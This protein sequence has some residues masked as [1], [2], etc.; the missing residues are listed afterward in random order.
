MNAPE[1][2]RLA[3]YLGVSAN[4]QPLAFIA[5]T[6]NQSLKKFKF[7]EELTESSL[8]KLVEDWQKGSLKTFLKTQEVPAE[9]FDNDV[10]VLVGKNFEEVVFDTTKDVFVE[11]YAPWCGHCK[12]LAPDYE[13]V[14]GMFKDVESVVVAKIDATANEVEG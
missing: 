4:D 13:K 5:D 8:K 1:N 3:E 9:A 7:T 6:R 14:A 10:R 11:F 2:G 12:K